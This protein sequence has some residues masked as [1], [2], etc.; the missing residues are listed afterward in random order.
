M[1]GDFDTLKDIDKEE[2][3][4]VINYIIGKIQFS[5]DSSL[6]LDNR[7]K[8]GGVACWVKKDK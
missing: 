6:S 1:F 2:R 7:G 8:R 5:M 4:E 3:N